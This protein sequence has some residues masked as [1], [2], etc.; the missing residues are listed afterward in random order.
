MYFF[1]SKYEVVLT[2][3]L[4]DNLDLKNKITEAEK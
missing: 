3:D 2:D 4:L 1:M